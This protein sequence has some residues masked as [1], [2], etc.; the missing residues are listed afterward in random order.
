MGYKAKQHN[1]SDDI[2]YNK[3]LKLYIGAD[4]KVTV[5]YADMGSDEFTTIGT[6][7]SAWVSS[8][9][10]GYLTLGGY[11]TNNTSPITISRVKIYEGEV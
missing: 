3:R 4:M 10:T 6:F 9:S 11:N 2:L 1:V 7:A 5:S 8:Y